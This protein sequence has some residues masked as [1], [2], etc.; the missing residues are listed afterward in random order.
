MTVDNDAQADEPEERETV[1][2]DEI[3]Q[4]VHDMVQNN[5]VGADRISPLH[6]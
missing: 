4:R 5:S 6:L 1:S 2:V 3:R